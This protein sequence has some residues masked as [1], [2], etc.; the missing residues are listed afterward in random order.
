MSGLEE[1]RFSLT[2][3]CK[4][5]PF[6]DIT[7]PLPLT[8]ST[9]LLGFPSPKGRLRSGWTQTPSNPLLSTQDNE[10]YLLFCIILANHE[11]GLSANR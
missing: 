3:E 10:L 4:I 2:K 6:L 8:E 9:A 11:G 5:R 7:A 1:Q